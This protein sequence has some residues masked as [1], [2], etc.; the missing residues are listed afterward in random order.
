MQVCGKIQEHPLFGTG[1]NLDLELSKT[2]RPVYVARNIRLAVGMTAALLYCFWDVTCRTQHQPIQCPKA[3]AYLKRLSMHDACIGC[4]W[5]QNVQGVLG[6]HPEFVDTG[7]RIRASTGRWQTVWRY[8]PP[9]N[10]QQAA[11]Q[12]SQHSK[13]AL[14]GPA[15]LGRHN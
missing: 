12:V 14:P 2:S 7:E 6:K 5:V 1:L 13:K 3:C 15:F 8:C 10:E 11:A 4:R 9:Q